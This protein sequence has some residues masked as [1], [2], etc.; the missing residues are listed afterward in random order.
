MVACSWKVWWW[1]RLMLLAVSQCLWPE[2][3]LLYGRERVDENSLVQLWREPFQ[4]DLRAPQ[5]RWPIRRSRDPRKKASKTYQREFKVLSSLYC[6]IAFRVKKKKSLTFLSSP[7]WRTDHTAALGCVFPPCCPWVP[8][9]AGS[10]HFVSVQ[11]QT[12]CAGSE[13]T[14]VTGGQHNMHWDLWGQQRLRGLWW[15]CR[16]CNRVR[17]AAGFWLSPLQRCETKLFHWIRKTSPEGHQKVH[18]RR[19]L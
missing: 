3:V 2:I 18:Q 4:D 7:I 11:L 17:G 13:T 8:L 5:W 12:G 1:F 9:P 14:V 19:A 10:E 15:V 6:C 16:V